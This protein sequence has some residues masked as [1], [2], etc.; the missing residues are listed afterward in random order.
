MRFSKEEMNKASKEIRASLRKNNTLPT[1][2]TM[3]DMDTGKKH[4]IS[5]PQYA[6]L[7]ENE[8]TFILSRGRRPNYV[9]YKNTANNPL[10]FKAQSYSHSCACASLCMCSMMLY[11]YKSENQCIEALGTKKTTTG[12][13]PSMLMN[14][15]HKLDMKA[16][17]IPRNRQA[18]KNSLIKNMP[19]IAHIDSSKA[20]CLNY[21]KNNFG[22]Y[23]C[24]YGV[25]GDYYK[26]A[27]PLRGLKSCKSS[28]LDNSMKNRKINYYAISLI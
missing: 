6:G 16:S 9:T 13:A 25:D 10:V 22:H 3:K 24:I 11:N 2:I 26:V 21:S 4:D 20:T 5:K 14:N 19:I 12:T 18:V 7:F 23:V 28:V 27:D 15:I 17:I 1:F 8:N